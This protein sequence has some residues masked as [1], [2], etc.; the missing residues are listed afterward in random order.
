MAQLNPWVDVT[1]YG[2]RG[3]ATVPQTTTA[4]SANTSGCTEGS[5]IVCLAEPTAFRDGDGIVL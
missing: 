4:K 3:G 5:P 1:A 2:A